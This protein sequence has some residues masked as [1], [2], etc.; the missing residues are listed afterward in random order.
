MTSKT[1]ILFSEK[2]P[3]H[4]K[5]RV[6]NNTTQGRHNDRQLHTRADPRIRQ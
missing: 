5:I 4:V 3:V 6:T 1:V 2:S